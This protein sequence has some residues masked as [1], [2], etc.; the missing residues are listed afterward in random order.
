MGGPQ[1]WCSADIVA[2]RAGIITDF[3]PREDSV[4]LWNLS[5]CSEIF[6]GGD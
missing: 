1:V 4:G 5:R 2:D 6:G 3:R